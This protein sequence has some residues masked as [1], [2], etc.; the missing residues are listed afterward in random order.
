MAD[1]D[2]VTPEES[3][4]EERSRLEE[5]R[6]VRLQKLE[7][8][9]AA[10]MRPYDD[11]YERTHVLA[12][13]R[14][15][16]ADQESDDPESGRLVSVAGRVMMR[17]VFGKLVFV[18]LQDGSGRCQVV[19]DAGTMG[20]EAVQQFQDFVDLGDHVGF[21]GRTARTKKGEPSV[22]ASGWT[23]LSKSLLPL[24]EKWSGLSDLEAR[25]RE[26]YLDLVSNP[27]TRERFRLRS[28]FVKEL[29]RYLDERG[30][31]E[32]DTPILQTKVTGALAKPFVT[33]HNAMDMRCVLRIAPETWLKQCV[34]GGMDRVYEVARCFR[35]EGMSPAHLQDFTMVEWYAAYWNYQDN[36]D[37]TE[38]LLLH[39]VDVLLGKREI[40]V[41]G[42]TIDFDTPWPR[43][44][45]RD[46]IL[47]DSGIDYA[48]LET[49]DDVRQAIR[50]K[51][52]QL[53]AEGV[54]QMSRGNL[55]D[56]LYKKV[57]RPQLVNPT[58]VTDH[59]IDLSP[60]ARM[61]DQDPT[62]VDRYQLVVNGWEIINAYSELVDPLDQRARFEQQ[63]AARDAGDEETLPL[64]EDYLRCM[65]H[66]MPPMSGWGMGV[67]RVVALL[68]GQDNLREVTLFPL[69]KPLDKS[70]EPAAAAP[71]AK[72]ATTDEG[73]TMSDEH[74]ALLGSPADDVDALGITPERA[75]EL[76]DE[77]VKTPSLRR[78]MEQ[79]SVVMGAMARKLGTNE[80]AWRLLGLLHNL[81]FDEV[82]EPE[83]HCLV[84]AEILGRE[85]VHPAGIHAIAA[86]ND[87]GLVATG[88]RC[89]SV[90]DHAV[91][92][93]EAVVGLIHAA[94]Q[95]LP[96]KDVQDLKVKS[97]R[98]R[99]KNPKFAANVER[100]LIERCAGAGLE[101]EAFLALAVEALQQEPVSEA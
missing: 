58:F 50:D 81:D 40:E 10:G 15:V 82:K 46:L 60:L 59:P 47:R 51:G 56:Q 30:F 53:E 18:H 29:R 28:R 34:A 76:F 99:F 33:H 21:E 42:R 37:F 101:L 86:H 48:E 91:S 19:L 41:E 98:K 45:M 97:V 54:D 27:E 25:Q 5:V 63:V 78:Q 85:G 69:L 49:A 75:R 9:K 71:A 93:A 52:I 7:A 100:D 1:V 72:E 39:L 64:D 62:R 70:D 61:N 89:V 84:T 31:E 17:R 23:F 83:R 16:A 92:A 66:G 44:A 68:T 73:E 4:A 11:R 43:I 95:V 13:A 14:Q 12:D 57:S 24:P 87:K 80:E 38:G 90:I 94:C 36:M 26:R 20:D 88:I 77:H 79:A 22:W 65:E 32:V 74:R 3:P 55:I 67:E 35:N 8:L 96:S 6:A 2:T